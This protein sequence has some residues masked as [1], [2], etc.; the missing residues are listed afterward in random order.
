DPLTRAFRA[1]YGD[2]DPVR[3]ARAEVL[4][5]LFRL[6]LAARRCCVH[7]VDWEAQVRVRV[8][9]AGAAQRL[10]RSA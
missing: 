1:G 3:W 2:C 5:A 4:A 9:E 6:K 7:D 10:A 8:T